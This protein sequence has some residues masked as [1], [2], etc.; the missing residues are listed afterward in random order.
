M[1]EIVG[2]PNMYN[3]ANEVLIN[4]YAT[5]ISSTFDYEKDIDIITE[6]IRT[7]RSYDLMRRRKEYELCTH[8]N[9]FEDEP[10]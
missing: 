7:I 9:L 8:H 6:L 10:I 3:Q 5:Y 1:I 4:T 2:E